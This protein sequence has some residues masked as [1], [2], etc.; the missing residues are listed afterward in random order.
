MMSIP[1]IMV[2]IFIT[3]KAAPSTTAQLCMHLF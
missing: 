3:D 2:Y 1:E